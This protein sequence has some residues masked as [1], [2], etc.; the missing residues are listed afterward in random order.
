M[1]AARCAAR[2]TGWYVV[3]ENVFIDSRITVNGD[4]HLI[5]AD[6]KELTAGEGIGVNEGNSLTIYGQANGTGSILSRL[7]W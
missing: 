2:N 4:V 5:R 1:R 7:H 6:G 3:Q